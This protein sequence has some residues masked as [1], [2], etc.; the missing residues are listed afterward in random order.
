MVTD[1]R[2]FSYW[3]MKE[4]KISSGV[5]DLAMLNELGEDKPSTITYQLDPISTFFRVFAYNRPADAA[6]E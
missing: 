1:Y 3:V 2:S 6:P 5:R 4:P